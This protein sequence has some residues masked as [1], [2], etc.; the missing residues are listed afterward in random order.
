VGV[1]ELKGFAQSETVQG[2]QDFRNIVFGE[3]DALMSKEG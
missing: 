2:Q 1:A 3:G